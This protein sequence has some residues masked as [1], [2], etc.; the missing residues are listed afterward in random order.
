MEPEEPKPYDPNKD[1]DRTDLDEINAK[2]EASGDF[3][4][5]REELK[6]LKSEVNQTCPYSVA[7]KVGKTYY[8]CTCGLSKK[9]PFCDSES[10]K[11]LEGFKPLK[12]TCTRE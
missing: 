9:Q 12:F 3:I 8:H 4:E 1:R 5:S 11:A 6:D 2:I 10:H 7:L